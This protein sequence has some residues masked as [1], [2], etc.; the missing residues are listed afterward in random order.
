[1]GGLVIDIIV[2]YLVRVGMRIVQL[3]RSKSWP[4]V[5]GKITSSFFVKAGYGCDIAEVH[6][7]YRVQG[8]LYSGQY[9][10]PSIGFRGEEYVANMSQGTK[11]IIRVKPGQPT[12][13]VMDRPGSVIVE[14]ANTHANAAN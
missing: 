1:M 14:D 4:M 5:T 2:E 6:Y 13:S 7:N 11:V 8:E 9:K 10:K 3:L 12:V